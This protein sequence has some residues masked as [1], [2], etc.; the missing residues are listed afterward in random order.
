MR[1]AVG[2]DRELPG[3]MFVPI[4][5]LKPVLADMIKTGHRAGPARPWLGIAAE[6]QSGR[7]FVTR[8]SPESPADEAGIKA[9]D[10][11]LAV[12]GDGVRTQAEFYRKVWGRGA[13]GTDIP[14]RVLQGIDIKDLKVRSIDRVEYF[15]PQTMF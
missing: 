13:A 3:N 4:D 9:G 10:I 15:R 12:G 1:D 2:G 8:V 6:E 5:V 14:L 11:I 7:L